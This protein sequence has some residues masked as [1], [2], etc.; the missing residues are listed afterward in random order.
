VL[1]IGSNGEDLETKVTLETSW[2]AD[3]TNEMFLNRIV[4]SSDDDI[5]FNNSNPLTSFTNTD[6]TGGTTN[7]N[8]VMV[9]VGN[10][11]GLGKNGFI[12]LRNPNG[13]IMNG[14]HRI[15]HVIDD[16]RFTI[17]PP[18][19][20][21]SVV[22]YMYR[23]MDGTPS[24][25]YVR[26]FELLTA[27]DYDTHPTA[28]SSNI[29]PQTTIP[30]LGVA[31]KTWSFNL[32][33]DINTTYL[34]GHRGGLVTELKF[35]MLKRSGKNPFDWSNVTSHWEFNKSTANTNNGIETVSVN[36]PSGVGTIVKNSSKTLT[37]QGS[38]YIGDIV[39]YNRKEIK[40]KIITE[41][42]FRF[43]I[44]SGVITN[45]PPNN[46]E[47]TA[48]PNGEGYYYKPFKTIE[49]RKYS[50]QIEKAEPNELFDG[51]PGDYELYPD[52]S[53]GWRDLL[54]H[55]FIEEGSNGVDWPFV[56]GRHHIFINNY[57]YIRRQLPFEFIDQSGLITVNPKNVC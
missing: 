24:E 9:T 55:G 7:T 54:Q 51:T 12:E 20:V 2:V 16:Y 44:Q 29:Y 38:K 53:I 36:Q 22:G 21:T 18:N 47:I 13:G 57:T 31:N 25:Y 48:N 43:G 45:Q 33:K 52:N 32:T 30:E 42:I 11:H 3:S 23:R 27:N 14:F 46:Q 56:N 40:E 35:C 6:L 19:V 15:H 28:F 5:N 17:Q 4:D 49:I 8:Y 26:E 39:E 1:E 50:N 37:Q 34:I 10:L 41:V